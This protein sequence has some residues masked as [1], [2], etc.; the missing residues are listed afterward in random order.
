MTMQ[1]RRQVPDLI[2]VRLRGLVDAGTGEEWR[3]VAGM[4]GFTLIP[5]SEEDQC[6]VG[7]GI[8]R[9]AQCR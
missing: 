4:P 8:T 5:D 7:I 6:P 9:L 1:V 3:T 2:L